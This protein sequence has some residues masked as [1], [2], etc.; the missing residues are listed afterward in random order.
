M[1]PHYN[2]YYIDG[3]MPT[4]TEN[5][6]P[7]PFPTTSGSF[8]GWLVGPEAWTL[9]A[10]HLLAH[11]TAKLGLGAKSGAGYGYGSIKT[12]PLSAQQ[13]AQLSAAHNPTQSAVGVDAH[14]NL[15]AQLNA[16]I[17]TLTPGNSFMV[18]V[19]LKKGASADEQRVIA[20]MIVAKLGGPRVAKNIGGKV[21]R[22]LESALGKKL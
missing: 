1:T 11:A 15:K 19:L 9:R 6:N 8:V 5:P 18:P 12:Q 16:D 22:D 17:A 2:A 4:G 3:K 13:V 14:A 10:V 20:E 21:L 7:V